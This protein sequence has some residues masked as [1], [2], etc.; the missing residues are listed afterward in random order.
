MTRCFAQVFLSLLQSS[1]PSFLRTRS[2]LVSSIAA[3]CVNR[4]KSPFSILCMPATHTRQD[5]LFI[6][7]SKASPTI[8]SHR[9]MH[10]AAP[11]RPLFPAKR[12][13]AP[14]TRGPVTSPL[15]WQQQLMPSLAHRRFRRSHSPLQH[16]SASQ[17]LRLSTFSFQRLVSRPIPHC[18][19][20]SPPLK[21][22]VCSFFVLK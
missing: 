3:S 11:I 6:P 22:A 7:Y 13:C 4:K 21:Y 15:F 8:S 18:V 16:P 19:L 20:L 1:S 17:L 5:C 10:A 12:A 2:F 14:V 9:T